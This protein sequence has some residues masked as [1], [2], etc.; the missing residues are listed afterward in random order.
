MLDQPADRP[1]GVSWSMD[2]IAF[3]TVA[4]ERVAADDQ[5][6]TMLASASFIEITSDLYTS[7]LAAYFRGDDEVVAWLEGS[8]EPEEL[9]HGRALR[10]YVT[11][12]WP[13]FD[14]DA[15]YANFLADY[16]RF[17]AVE[18]LE[19]TQALEMAA[20]CVVETGTS[21]FYR[22]IAT[23]APEPV[24]RSLAANISSDEVRHYKHFYHYFERYRARERPDRRAILRTLV[25][26]VLEVSSEDSY[27]AFKHVR[28]ARGL[29]AEPRD[30]SNYRA[31][32]RRLAQ[33]YFP[34]R[35]AV[36]MVTKPLALGAVGRLVLPP[37]TL[38]ARRFL[39]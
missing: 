9:Q 38:V 32:F 14:W 3:D 36:K 24:L 29:A 27:T 7:N 21:S 17:C 35:M 16:R 30:Y 10:R 6:F 5:L 18:K 11:T 2:E 1:G 12:A 20:R 28:A 4:R 8:W 26:R 25:S 39:G 37:L 19:P 33:Q 13:D 23:L 22:M 31:R 34:H 15:A